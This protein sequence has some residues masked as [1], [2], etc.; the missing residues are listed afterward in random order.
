M[1]AKFYVL[2]LLKRGLSPFT[3]PFTQKNAQL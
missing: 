3:Y 2:F 1:A